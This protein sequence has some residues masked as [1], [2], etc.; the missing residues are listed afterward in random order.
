MLTP[1]LFPGVFLTNVKQSQLHGFAD[2]SKK[3]YCAMVF[4]VCG[5]TE[6]IHKCLLSAMAVFT[7]HYLLLVT[8]LT[9]QFPLY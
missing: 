9:S 2:A 5:T 1:F 3:A 7:L 6:G 4:L 8:T